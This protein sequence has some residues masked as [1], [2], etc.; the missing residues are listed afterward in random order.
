MDFF[1]SII[2]CTVDKISKNM[3]NDFLL[4]RNTG[5]LHQTSDVCVMLIYKKKRNYGRH[6]FT[7]VLR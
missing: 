4:A 6:L 3:S 7:S 1:K 5:M 2:H